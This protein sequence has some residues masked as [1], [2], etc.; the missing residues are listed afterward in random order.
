M[1]YIGIDPGEA[2]CG[3]AA[4]DVISSTAIRVEARTYSVTVRGGYLNMVNS[5]LDLLPHNRPTTIIAED[6]QIRHTRHQSFNHGNTLRFLGALEHGVSEIDAFQFSLIPPSDHGE[7]ETRGLFGH[8]L[9]NYRDR[10][11][12]ARS[13]PWN[14]CLSAWRAIG[15]YLL[16]NEQSTLLSLRKVKRSSKCQRWL[17]AATKGNEH[18][19]PPAWWIK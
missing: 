4:L 10:W 18:I 17:P 9:F 6:F 3:F 11:P 5:I 1:L 2:W 13:A 14:H 8:V 19:A 16:Q 7:R 15:I 12:R